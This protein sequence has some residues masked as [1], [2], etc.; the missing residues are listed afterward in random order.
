MPE[1]LGHGDRGRREGSI[2]ARASSVARAPG[3][4]NDVCLVA[5]K[6]SPGEEGG[7]IAVLGAR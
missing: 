7:G 5:R 4:G 1:G 3:A 6:K 2:R